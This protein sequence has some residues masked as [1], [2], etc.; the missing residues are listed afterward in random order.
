[1]VNT[2]LNPGKKQRKYLQTDY[3][4]IDWPLWPRLVDTIARY[5]CSG[6]AFEGS[7]IDVMVWWWALKGQ[8]PGAEVWLT[9]LGSIYSFASALFGLS[10]V[11]TELTDTQGPLRGGGVLFLNLLPN[12]KL[13]LIILTV[14]SYCEQVN[15]ID[16]VPA[17]TCKN[18][19]TCI[20]WVSICQSLRTAVSTNLYLYISGEFINSINIPCSMYVL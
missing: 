2:P 15:A 10:A 4:S 16:F 9:A 17:V 8:A 3:M 19:C 11:S 7:E 1:M 13:T 6:I 14:D 20:R 5:W 18:W 12:R